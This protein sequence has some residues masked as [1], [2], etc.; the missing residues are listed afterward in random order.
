MKN[1]KTTVTRDEFE[2]STKILT[3]WLAKV[4]RAKTIVKYWEDAEAK[5]RDAIGKNVLVAI[6]T[7]NTGKTTLQCEAIAQ[8]AAVPADAK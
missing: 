5:N 2:R 3:R 7:D 8:L 6:V 4:E 1:G